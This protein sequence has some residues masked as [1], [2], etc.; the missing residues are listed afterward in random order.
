MLEWLFGKEECEE[1]EECIEFTESEEECLRYKTALDGL[2]KG[3][4]NDL[5]ANPD[6]WPVNIAKRALKI[7][8]PDEHEDFLGV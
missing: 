1:C 8:M 7:P 6:K 5:A 3:E 2:A 4:Y